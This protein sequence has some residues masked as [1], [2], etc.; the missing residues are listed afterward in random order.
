MSLAPST[1]NDDQELR[2]LGAS[3]RNRWRVSER[4]ADLVRWPDVPRP[5]TVQAVTLSLAAALCL[6]VGVGTYQLS[7]LMQ[8]PDAPSPI[9]A[10][11]PAPTG[12][13]VADLQ[14]LEKNNDVLQNF[15]ALDA[16]YGDD[17]ASNN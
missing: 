6:V 5:I 15:D 4:R 14:Y 8:V 13:A 17:D 7:R 12:S 11:I 9:A 1:D 3:P 2:P 16:L 10:N